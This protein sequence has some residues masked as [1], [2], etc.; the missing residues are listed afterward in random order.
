MQERIQNQSVVISQ[1]AMGCCLILPR[2]TM[3]KMLDKT[4]AHTINTLLALYSYINGRNIMKNIANIGLSY[5]F[6][7]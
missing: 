6:V 7:V 2:N 3:S 4:D 1:S 5:S